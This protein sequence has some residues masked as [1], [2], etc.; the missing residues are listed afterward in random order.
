MGISKNIK[1]SQK[2]IILQKKFV[3]INIRGKRINFTEVLQIKRKNFDEGSPEVQIAL[4]TLRIKKLTI[5]L[6]EHKHDYSTK[7]GLAK[8]IGK[9]SR[10]LR[11]L[12]QKNRP[13]YLKICQLLGLKKSIIS[14][15]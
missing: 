5:H 10:L 8:I 6:Q 2:N 13:K 3:N 4:M 9:R 15:V 7:N 11:Y 12:E 14:T 1:L